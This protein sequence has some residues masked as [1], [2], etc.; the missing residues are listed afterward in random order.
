MNSCLFVMF[1][2]PMQT[3]FR[4]DVER[5]FVAF[6]MM[7]WTDWGANPKIEQAQMDGSARRAIVTG[8][9][10]WPNGL[11]I[12][13][14]T[15]SLFWADAKLDVIEMSDLNGGNRQ[16]VMS[17]AAN[18]HPYGL[19]VYQ[20]VLY[21]TDW[22]NKSV[23]RFNLSSGNQDM[24]VTG[25]QQPMD[26]H[27]FDPSLIF[28]GNKLTFYLPFSNSLIIHLVNI[29]KIRTVTVV[30]KSNLNLHRFL[31]FYFS[32]FSVVLD[33]T[34]KRYQTLVRVFHHMSKHLE[35][36]QKYSATRRIFNSILG[37]WKCD[38]T[39]S[40]EFD[41][42]LAVVCNAKLLLCHFFFCRIS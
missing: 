18:I 17:S 6:S 19:A 27:V 35:V 2:P 9:L 34:E 7:Y 13:Q 14:A 32:V 42:L 24:I 23:S 28:S 25:L 30:W 40:L 1:D 8:N 20:N 4:N 37:V 16:Y 21:W 22:G 26:I 33:S 41:L 3:L 5:C 11:T 29:K 10:A 36:R 38:E 15:K 31:R 39:V 12:D